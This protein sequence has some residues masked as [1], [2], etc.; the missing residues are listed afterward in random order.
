MAI[1]TYDG[2]EN[3]SSFDSVKNYL[4][5]TNTGNIQIISSTDANGVT[6]RNNGS[7]LKMTSS[8]STFPRVYFKT[9]TG[10]H[11]ISGVV[12]FAIYPTLPSGGSFGTFTPI[13]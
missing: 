1:I 13:S 11:N 2:F 5:Y 9:P 10:T 8:G 12:G 4:N 7:C 3:Y 6:P